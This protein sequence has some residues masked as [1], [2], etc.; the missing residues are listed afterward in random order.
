[1]AKKNN[2]K[3]WVG[4]KVKL[5]QTGLNA[6]YLVSLNGHVNDKFKVIRIAGSNVYLEHPTMASSYPSGYGIPLSA[7]APPVEDTI[8]GLTEANTDLTKEVAELESEIASNKQKIK[9]M[10]E[11]NLTEFSET[12]FKAYAILGIIENAKTSKLDK[13]KAIAK[14]VEGE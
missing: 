12:D 3:N 4:K 6:G 7:V 14:L 13:A 9:F 2:T 8:E 5:S 11:N 1:M 10:K